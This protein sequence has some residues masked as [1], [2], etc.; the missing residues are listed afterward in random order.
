MLKHIRIILENN[1]SRLVY[2]NGR[3]LIAYSPLL[4]N[5]TKKGVLLYDGIRLLRKDIR[6]QRL[7]RKLH[8]DKILHRENNHV[9]N[10]LRQKT[11]ARASFSFSI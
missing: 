2:N 1:G 6:T 11:R 4:F 3:G 10:L 7:Y 9:L 5:Q 8:E